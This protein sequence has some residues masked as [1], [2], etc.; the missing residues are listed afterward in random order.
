MRLIW[1][2]SHYRGKRN[3]PAFVVRTLEVLARFRWNNP[4]SWATRRRRMHDGSSD[5]LPNSTDLYALW[6]LLQ[7]PICYTIHQTIAVWYGFG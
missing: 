7:A 2:R 3:E 6:V 1:H 5:W 4:I